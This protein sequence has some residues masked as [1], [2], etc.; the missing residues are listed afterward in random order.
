[1]AQEIE[2][3]LKLGDHQPY[4]PLEVDDGHLAGAELPDR[5]DPVEFFANG[6]SVLPKPKRDADGKVIKDN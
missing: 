2:K 5:Y 4:W 1:M 6:S 3:D